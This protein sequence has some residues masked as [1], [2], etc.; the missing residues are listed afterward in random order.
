MHILIPKKTFLKNRLKCD[1]E[2]FV[3]F[4]RKLCDPDQNYRPTASNALKHKFLLKNIE[5]KGYK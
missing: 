2:D 1:D 4:I 3:D 5:W